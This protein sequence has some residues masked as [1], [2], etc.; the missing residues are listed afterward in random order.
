M[1]TDRDYYMNAQEA[2]AYGIVDALA[3]SV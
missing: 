3:D 2:V 1:D